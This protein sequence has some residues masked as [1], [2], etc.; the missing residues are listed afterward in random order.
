MSVEL[1]SLADA[2]V[3]EVKLVHT[4]ARVPTRKRTTDAG[5]DIYAC[6]TVILP[7]GR[8]TIVH[9]GLRL[10][11]PPGFYYTIEGRSSLWSKGIVPNRGIIDATFNDE[12]VV[13]LVNFSPDPYEVEVGHRIAQLLLH[14]QLHM[15]FKAI[16]QFSPEY[17][18]RGLQG[19]GS[20]GK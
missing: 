8:A 10:A 3:M 15:Q 7:P 18:Q 17:N 16:D 9:T 12:V 1:I 4:E 14:Q 11:A 2:V 20:T 19:F 13:S 6:E 5:Y